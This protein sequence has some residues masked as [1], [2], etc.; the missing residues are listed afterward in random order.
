MFNFK[1]IDTRIILLM[2]LII[3]E[4][5]GVGIV[6]PMLPDLFIAKNSALLATNTI[7][8]MRHWYY[9]LSLALWPIGMF[10]GTPYLG[11]LSD[12]FGRKK[13]FI[14]CLIMTAA[15]YALLAIAV[16]I[17]SV[18]LF[19]ITRMFSGFFAGSYD[20]A[21]A[22]AADISTPETK[23]RNMGWIV[24]ANAVGFFIG[25][26]ITSL[27]IYNTKL[28]FLGITTPFWIATLLSLTNALLIKVRF[29]DTYKSKKEHK[30]AFKKVFSAFLFVFID[31]RLQ[32]LSLI[33]LVFVSGFFFFFTVLP[34][35]L[36]KVFAVKANMIALFYCLI[37]LVNAFNMLLVQPRISKILSPEKTM[38]YAAILSGLSLI[39]L[40]FANN[41]ITFAIIMGVFVLV[42]LPLYSNFLAVFSNAVSIDE[43]GQAMGGSASIASVAFIAVSLLM[44][45]VA[46]INPKISIIISSVLFIISWILMLRRKMHK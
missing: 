37:G 9:G 41:L 5:M 36:T 4:V 23:V 43:Q 27:T 38:I 18:I 44:V 45:L 21:Q 12:K 40:L 19:L 7:D 39:I 29:T 25:P 32:Y 30:I 15:S 33:F 6:F 11:E 8:V 24:F 28:D 22:S 17:H 16:Y 14:T 10:F 3:I 26:L 42:E 2:L 13:I 34:L 1:N 20:I 35:Y 31:K 46:N